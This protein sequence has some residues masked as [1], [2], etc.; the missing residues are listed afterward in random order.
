[1]LKE[2]GEWF[3]GAIK[4]IQGK[5]WRIWIRIKREGGKGRWDN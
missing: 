5:S 4:K 1:M 3:V 2:D